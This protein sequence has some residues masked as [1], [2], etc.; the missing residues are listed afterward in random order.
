[1][2]DLAALK[3]QIG[4]ST[5]PGL[6]AEL[7][8]AYEELKTRYFKRDFRPGGLEAGRFAEAAFRILEFLAT[9]KF[10]RVGKSLPK[11]PALLIALESAD[12]TKIHESVRIH[13]PRALAAVYNVRNKR[14]IGHLAAD[15][16]PNAMDAEYLVST[17]NWVLAELVRLLHRCSPEEAQRYVEA[18]VQRQA[19]LVQVFGDTAFV[20]QADIGD[21]DEILLLLYHQGTTGATLDEL[22]HWMPSTKRAVIRARL[23][24]LEHRQRYV[25]R[26]V[27]RI[28][29]TDTGTG[30]VESKLVMR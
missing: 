14:D 10:T 25:R 8:D 1:V 29:I 16:D 26:V 2:T 13:I 9:G 23:S 22:D 20:L 7:I 27:G 12:A 30:H 3:A 24:D 18:I 17:C 21:R 15:V 5:D 6:A 28:Y 11:V 4:A 19:P